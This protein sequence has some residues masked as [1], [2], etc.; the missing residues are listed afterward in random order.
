M[1]TKSFKYWKWTLSFYTNQLFVLS[2]NRNKTRLHMAWEIPL[3][4]SDVGQKSISFFRASIW[5][6]FSND[7]NILSTA[8]S[9]THNYKKL[10]LKNLQ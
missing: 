10:V 2:T 6:K 3:A 4:K 1:T 5:N 9:S 7:L 8:P